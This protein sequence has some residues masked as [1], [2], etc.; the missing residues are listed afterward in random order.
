VGVDATVEKRT[1]AIDALI[2]L[3]AVGE[4]HRGYWLDPRW[5]R[6]GLMSEACEVVTD[7]WFN[8]LK[9][10]LLRVPKAATNLPS[11]RISEKQRMRLVST[12]DGDSISGRQPTEVWEIT[13]DEWN[14]RRISMRDKA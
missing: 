6:R 4:F 9:F 14:S 5:H 11:R 10:P 13:A 2:E 1:R 3:I 8:T 12:K 7:Y